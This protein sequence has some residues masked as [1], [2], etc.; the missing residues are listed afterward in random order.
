MSIHSKVFGGTNFEPT[1]LVELLRWRAANFSDYRAYT[2]LKDGETDELL[3]TY[4]ELDQRARAI[5]AWLQ[6]LGATGERALLIYPP[7]MDY[8]VAFFGCLYAG[9]TAV[10]AYPPDPTRLNRTLPRLQAIARDAQASIAL[11]SDSI[12]SMIKIMRIGSKVTDSLEKL[13][14]LKK[15][16]STLSSFISQKAAIVNAKDLSDLNWLSTE[17]IKN[18]QAKDWKQPDIDRDTLAFLQYTSG[19]T[20][21]PR[22]VMLSHENLL[23]NLA[24]IY[25]GFGHSPE[26]E[27]VIWLPIYHDMGLI[28][29][30]LQPLYGGMPVTLMSP[31]DFLQRPLRWLNA[32]NRIKNR[33]IISGGPNFAYDLCAR[34]V[35]PEQKEKLHLGHWKVAFSGAEPVR[36]E[37]IERFSETFKP[38]GFNRE[39]FYPCYGLAEATLFVSG[40]YNTNPP[41]ILNIKR[42]ELKNNRFVEASPGENDS[43]TAVGCGHTYGDQIISIVNPET[44]EE[45]QQNE[46]GEIWI[47]GT[48][49]AKG[50]WNRTEETKETFQARIKGKKKRHF[51]RT[52]DM[53]FLKDGEL[54]I[55]GR[56]KDLII[57]R[58]RNHYPQDIE[59]TVENSHQNL[60]PGCSAVFSVDIESQERLI[61]VVEVRNPKKLNADEVIGAI[62]RNVTEAHELQA[63]AV[64]LIKPRSISKTSSGKIQRRATKNEF[65]ENKLQIVAEWRASSQLQTDISKQPEIEMAE[66][67]PEPAKTKTPVT[68]KKKSTTVASLETW[69]ISKVAENLEIDAKEIDIH[70]PFVSFGLDSAQAVGLAGDLE[71]WLG[72]K[73]SPTLVWDYPTIESL[74]TFLAEDE[75][76][77]VMAPK[78]KGKKSSESEPIAII[79]MGCRFPKANNPEEF[80]QLLRNGIDAISEVPADR[81]D[82]DAFYDSNPDAQGKMITRCGGFLDQ[83]DQFDPHFFGISPREA[84]RMDPQQRLLLEVTWEALEDA[85]IQSENIAGSDTGVFVGVNNIDY[86]ARVYRDNFLIDAYTGIGNSSSITANRLSY[87]FNLNGPSIAIDTACSSSLVA[88]HLAIQSLRNGESSLAIAGGVNVIISPER[89][90]TFS[91]ARLMAADGRCKTFDA[92]ADGYGRGEGCGIIILKRL[93]DALQNG[94]QIL[95][96][97]RG[98]AINQDGKSNGITAPNGLAQQAVIQ[99]AMSNAN[100]KP[101]DVSYVEAHGT[102]TIL[103]DPIEIQ[104]LGTVHQNRPKDRPCM[105]GSVKTNIGHLESAA[106]IAGVIKAVLALK[107]EEIP[108][109]LH[110]KTINPQIPIEKYPLIF[111]SESMPWKAGSGRRIAGVSSFGFGGTNAHVIIEEPLKKTQTENNP[112]RPEHLLTLSAKSEIALKD[113]ATRFHDF[114]AKNPSLNLADACYTTNNGRSHFSNRLAITAS[115]NEKLID[116][117]AGYISGKEISGIHCGQV[118]GEKHHKIAFLFT[119]QGS[120]YPGMGRQLYDTQPTFKKALDQCNEILKNYLEKP[121]LSVIYPESEQDALLLNETIY[122]QPAL[123]ALEYA[124]AELWK[125]WGIEPD[126]VYGHS[127]GEYVAACVAGFFSLEDGLKLI[128]ARGR[129]MQSLLRNGEMAVIFANHEKVATVL[130]PYLDRVSIAAING[131]ENVVIS[132]NREAV[133]TIVGLLNGDGINSRLLRVSH[134]FHSPLMDTI[135]DEFENIASEIQPR[136]PKIP[137]ISNLNNKILGPWEIPDAKYWRNHIR[138]AVQFLGGM[139]TLVAESCDIFLEIGPNPTLLGMGRRCVPEA[140]ARWLPSLREKKDDWQ[141]MLDSLAQLYISGVFIDWS[142]FERDY[143]R[144]R[145]QL[146]TYPFQRRRYWLDEAGDGKTQKVTTSLGMISGKALHPLLNYRMRSPA[147]EDTVFESNFSVDSLPLLNDHRVFGMPIFPA[148]AYLEMALAAS[149]QIFGDVKSSIEEVA[150]LEA[151]TFS[152]GELRSVQLV[153]N[154]NEAGDSDFKIF[155]LPIVENGAQDDWKLHA[156]GKLRNGKTDR[157]VAEAMIDL[158][159]IKSRCSEIIDPKFYYQQLHEQGLEYGP[160]FQAIQEIWRGAGEVLG[161]VQLSEANLNELSSYHLHPA[162]LDASFQLLGAILAD[163]ANDGIYLPIGLEKL[164]LFGKP[165]DKLWCHVQLRQLAEESRALLIADLKLYNNDRQLVAAVDGLNLKHTNL[166]AL[167]SIVDER[168]KDWLYQIEW[169][170]AESLKLEE[171]QQTQ[172]P[173]FWLFFTD[174]QNIGSRLSEQLEEQDQICGF[175]T[176]GEKFE[177]I[178]EGKWQIDPANVEN[179]HQLVREITGHNGI[180][181]RGVVHLWSLDAQSP[182]D[183][184]LGCGSTLHLVQALI[185][186]NLSQLPQ[187]WLV[188]RG[189]QAVTGATAGIEV[190]A[191]ALWGMGRVIALEHPELNCIRFDLDPVSDSDEIPALFAEIWSGDREGQV[192]RRQGKRYVPRLIRAS[193]AKRDQQNQSW[194]NQPFRLTISERGVLDNLKFEP[195]VRQKPGAGQA[196]IRVRATGQNFRDVLNALDLYPGDPGLL[197]GECAGEI[198]AIGENVEHL[199]VGD[200]VMA[201][202]PGSFS[203]HVITYADLVTQIPDQLSFEDAA[204]IPITFLTAYYA[205]NRLAKI[206]EGDKV[207]IH[208]ASGGVGLA[209]IQLAK[210]AGAEVFAT[211]GSVP[212][213]EFLRSLGI[214][215]VMDSRSLDFADEVLKITGG[216]GVDIVLNSLSGDFIPKGLSSLAN[217]G[218]F[219]EIGKIGIWDQ[220]QVAEFRNDVSYFTIALDDLSYQNPSLIKEMFSELMEQFNAGELTPLHHR[221]FPIEDVVNA[222]RFMAQAKH[223]GKVIINQDQPSGEKEIAIKADASYLITGGFGALGLMTAK[224][225]T[226][227]GARHLVLADIFEA[228]EQANQV[229]DGLQKAG[230]QVETAVGD[231]ARKQ[232]VEKIFTEL[233][234]SQSKKDLVMPPLR[235][236]IHLAGVLD[237]GVILQQNWEKFTRVMEPKVAGSWHLHE[238]T[239]NI[240]LDFFFMF[241]SV[242]SIFGSP[243]QSNY[244]AAN[245]FMDGLAHH[246]IALGL[247]AQSINWGP[248]AQSGMAARLDNKD[249]R[250]HELSGLGSIQPDQ[251]F[252]LLEKLLDFPAAQVGVLPIDWSQFAKQF[253]PGQEPLL[254]SDFVQKA[255]EKQEKTSAPKSDFLEKLKLTKPAD[256]KELLMEHLRDK[257]IKILGLEPSYPL[258]TKQP[259][260]EMGLDSLMAIELKNALSSAVGQNL[261]ATLLFNYPTIESLASHLL[262]DVL[263]LEKT[264]G[265]GERV[266]EEVEN[267]TGNVEDLSD[268]LVESLLEEK[269]ATIE[270]MIPE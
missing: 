262:S 27:G 181:L 149:K 197:G 125:S 265:L 231:I 11:T 177:K 117:L 207:L 221:V 256:R 97:I 43:Q 126:Y 102:G 169:R 36:P 147:I 172:S 23:Y 121:L 8:V 230:V 116:K 204:T 72:K 88:I 195:I 248:W 37:T 233:A 20:G 18:E 217:E 261:P 45:C 95:A 6:S 255:R 179:F 93:S 254:I 130:E 56:I 83:V 50:Y 219:L 166:A 16:G 152:D 223:I 81:W 77:S 145:M 2:Y 235:G 82:Q 9:V 69:L 4:A 66:S 270:K 228:S 127:I 90:I 161:F 47:S 162:L 201:I 109:N 210:N 186:A 106:G 7:G 49:V 13:P 141:V 10:P 246:R 257:A 156:T 267:K 250:R 184:I 194:Q 24:L 12:L 67:S 122:T 203:S 26:C 68:P 163:E 39:A 260:N 214:Q 32:I 154:S 79:G 264:D 46:I 60:R 51:L 64:V 135:L 63:Y 268:E 114:V 240:E 87:I 94:D 62:R 59:F 31:I 259:L 61:I 73:L 140:S 220:A 92:S 189:A 85:G 185:A 71:E 213:R 103:G 209:A 80:W 136:S 22:G 212:K 132:G 44:F 187:L 159:Q 225:L 215:H 165:S 150:I 168:L 137:L 229:I 33:P 99:Q 164:Q 107:N 74:A 34:K 38:C 222:F 17:D 227:Q 96:L 198:V 183:T 167:S 14:F 21:V 142:G 111:P 170:P 202:A 173:G 160:R 133:L 232:D 84:A 191:S 253:D 242:A 112:E 180:P 57:I 78:V 266:V 48:S 91:H 144:S 15:F 188:T 176:P 224:W 193:I 100:I 211:A 118:H 238:A 28:G 123:F 1:T 113:L 115:S 175:V 234:N 86:S 155:S 35:T 19:S 252:K 146:P 124:L 241:S 65:L 29:G 178:A 192:A 148:V 98:S 153:L 54:F 40:G 247:P 5:G 89:T 158:E 138:Q 263:S 42:S 41:I 70:E 251:G 3:M 25:D 190:N 134:A 131:P 208:T 119:G 218:R 200:R 120:Q 58:G 269:L 105:V 258:D 182:I 244:A 108:K 143:R 237:D 104:A 174:E 75:T 196:E 226:E 206:S 205:L 30:V 236:I 216:E 129:L 110:F 157:A 139:E 101:E 199:K 128:T 151:M 53:G 171:R 243:G 76:I 239:K 55:T 52:G 245:A 249:Q